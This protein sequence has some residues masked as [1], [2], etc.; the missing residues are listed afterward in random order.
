M[1]A[2]TSIRTARRGADIFCKRK[3]FDNGLHLKTI[4]G[5]DHQHR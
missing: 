5:R 3:L 2:A 4:G 1:L